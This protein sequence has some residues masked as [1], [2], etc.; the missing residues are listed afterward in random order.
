MNNVENIKFRNLR[1]DE[2]EV[3]RG[4]NVGNTGKVELLIYK[5]A[6]VDAELLN[7]TVGSHYWKKYYKPVNGMTFCGIAIKNKST[8]EWIEKEDVGSEQNFEKE[9]SIASDAFKRAGFAWGIGVSLYT[10]PK[11]IVTPDN[12]YT[13]YS[14]REI[15]YDENNK[16]FNL[17]IEDNKGNVVFN[18]ENGQIAKIPEISREEVLKAVCAE[19]R[20]AGENIEQLK[21]FFYYYQE[22]C[23]NFDSWNANLVRKLWNKWKERAK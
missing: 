17:I 20:E 3:R 5:T 1:A 11:I 12:D 13:T 14:V 7:E 10:A 19:N 9:K 15:G 23:E 6:R 16:I 4:R 18:F 21:K 8:G 2:I 22:K